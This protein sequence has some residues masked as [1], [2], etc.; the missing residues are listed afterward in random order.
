MTCFKNSSTLKP[1]YVMWTLLSLIVIL[2]SIR[3]LPYI[4]HQFSKFD[5]SESTHQRKR[6]AD[7]YYTND[8][9]AVFNT[10]ILLGQF[11]YKSNKLKE[12][13][14]C[15]LKTQRFDKIMI[16]VPN[17]TSNVRNEM[18]DL[19][20]YRG[21][22]GFV[23]PYT[24]IGKVIRKNPNVKSLLYVHD[25]LLISKSILDKVGKTEW[26]ISD[27]HQIE[28]LKRL[29]ADQ[30]IRLYENGNFFLNVIKITAILLVYS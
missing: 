20:S 12:W 4:T 21:D 30:V 27:E 17:N 24:N 6:N 13:S 15:W 10:T 16:A 25:D 22:N 7:A 19:I 9:V 2:Y 26:I 23:S 29:D 28:G 14:D 11:N 18:I 8:S 1:S 5:L 3:Y